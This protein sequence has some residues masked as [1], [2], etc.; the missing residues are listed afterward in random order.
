MSD[1][2]ESWSSEN[3]DTI[4]LIKID[5]ISEETT[6]PDTEFGHMNNENSNISLMPDSHIE[7]SAMG[8][9]VSV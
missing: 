3:V 8:L 5:Q 4:A 1:D 6:T 9:A 2:T 7:L